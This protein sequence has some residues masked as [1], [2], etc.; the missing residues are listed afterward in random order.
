MI[1]IIEIIA[2]SEK[3][4]YDLHFGSYKVRMTMY[5]DGIDVMD[6]IVK[7]NLTTVD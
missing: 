2:S 5:E 7:A 4:C 6:P 3:D 1:L